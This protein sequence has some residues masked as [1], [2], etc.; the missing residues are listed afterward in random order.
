MKQASGS[1]SRRE[2]LLGMAGAALAFAQ[3]RNRMYNPELAVHTSLWLEEAGL[4]H[5]PLANILDEAFRSMRRAGYQR[6][7]LNSAFLGAGLRERTLPLLRDN[8]LQ[9]SVL[10]TSGPLYAPPAAEETRNQ[11][12]QT[13]QL[14]A[15]DDLRFVNFN[16]AAR[17][18]GQ[19]TTSAE[20]EI[21]AYQLNRLGQELA[22]HRLELMFHHTQL[23]MQQD[24]RE[25][26]YLLAHTEPARVS[27]CLD[28]DW[29]TRAGLNPL[30]LIDT[31]GPRLR[32]LHLR[33]PR[34]GVNQELLADGDI[35]MARIARLLR[36]M[37]YD[38]FL[39]VE[40]LY[41]ADM[42]RQRGVTEDL[43]RSRWYMQEIFGSRPGNP[44]VDMGPHVRERKT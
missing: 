16:L 18:D 3:P 29:V 43:S 40:L 13:A 22:Q 41:D 38:G 11:V 33:N 19:P 7:E 35:D 44:P 10:Y 23:E 6:L 36:Q 30:S 24:A 39:V 31:A 26:R 17:P 34:K 37:R 9:P 42:K 20:L 1:H 2:V 25:W 4:R 5:Q 15:G 12:L 8:R 28:V 14:L 21:Q 32:S 27:C